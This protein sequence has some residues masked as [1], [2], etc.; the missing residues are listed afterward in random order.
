MNETTQKLLEQIAANREKLYAAGAAQGG[1][2]VFNYARYPLPI[3]YLNGDVSTMTKETA[4]DMTYSFEENDMSGTA[5][6][7]WQG[8]SSLAY[9]KKNYTI[10]FDTAFEA[11]EGWGEQKKYCLKAN[12]IDFSHS[13]NIV[14]AKIWGECVRRYEKYVA[15]YYP[16]KDLPNAGAVDGFPIAL[17]INGTY[18]GLYSFNIPKDAW[19]FGLDESNA[20]HCIVSAGGG[21]TQTAFKEMPYIDGENFEFEHV[22][23]NATDADKA[24]FQTSIQ[25]L[26]TAL[27]N[28]SSRAALLNDV[29]KYLDIEKAIVYM[30]F[31]A[32]TAN[33][34]GITKNY[35]LMTTD[36][37]KWHMSA[38]DLDS[39][40]GN[41]PYGDTYYYP[42]QYTY[43]RLAETNMIFKRIYEYAP[44][45]L[46]RWD[47]KLYML[48]PSHIGKEFYQYSVKI[49]KIYFDEEVKIWRELP[50]TAT[51]NL[52]QIMS[53]CSIEDQLLS[54]EI[55]E[56]KSSRLTS[57]LGEMAYGGQSIDIS[58][59]GII[60]YTDNVWGGKTANI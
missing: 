42:G 30:I 50:G 56:L 26:Y 16:L 12:Y 35:L 54:K 34:D 52:A 45:L 51:N 25:N 55:E 40:F 53:F 5:S 33:Y 32:R 44:D 20:N 28:C 24:R 18:A 23:D 36:G 7:K 8:S 19:M 13:R 15:T 11:K 6:V 39:T 27:Q 49:P 46:Y 10:K 59:I 3:L 1:S 14:S 48:A 38:Y 43:A 17:V 31:V 22:S 37:G 57:T 47:E 60:E 4:V 9:P 29:G 2:S 21:V 41:N 58:T